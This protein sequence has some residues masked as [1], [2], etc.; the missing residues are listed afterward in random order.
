MKLDQYTSQNC[1]YEKKVSVKP[2][3]ERLSKFTN[4]KL[5]KNIRILNEEKE[6]S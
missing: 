1:F 3:R 2:A 5:L 6:K 4:S